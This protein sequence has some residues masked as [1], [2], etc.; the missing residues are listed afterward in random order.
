MKMIKI[1]TSRWE[2]QIVKINGK[3]KRLRFDQPEILKK[4][5]IE[6][7]H[8]VIQT[9]GIKGFK[10][11]LRN[12]FSFLQ[13]YMCFALLINYKIPIFNAA[14]AIK[15]IANVNQ[16]LR[17]FSITFSKRS[18]FIFI[19]IKPITK[20]GFHFLNVGNFTTNITF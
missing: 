18:K 10:S 7:L 11:T 8:L 17:N 20:F 4:M 13:L 14:M 16:F 2:N 6:V 9:Y 19:I 3:I 1:T 15:T 12:F 5:S